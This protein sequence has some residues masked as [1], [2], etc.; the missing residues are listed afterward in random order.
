MRSQKGGKNKLTRNS[1]VKK[2]LKGKGAAND[3]GKKR[4]MTLEDTSPKKASPK[5]ASPKKA[6]PKNP[7]LPLNPEQK[8][9]LKVIRSIRN[10]GL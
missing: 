7:R 5:K 4:N 6:S 1:P 3:K 9:L 10:L 2:V 8:K